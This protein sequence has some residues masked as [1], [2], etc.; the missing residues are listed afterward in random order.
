MSYIIFKIR[1]RMR[2]RMRQKT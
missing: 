2:P 1:Q